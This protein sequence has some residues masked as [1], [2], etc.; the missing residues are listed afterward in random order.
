MDDLLDF[1]GVHDD[2]RWTKNRVEKTKATSTGESNAQA[3]KEVEIKRLSCPV[4]ESAMVSEQTNIGEG[5]APYRKRRNMGASTMWELH[6]SMSRESQ[7]ANEPS[8]SSCVHETA[9]NTCNLT[10]VS[11]AYGDLAWPA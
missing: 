2:C 3:G 8:A 7:C 10:P 11:T 5:V 9:A 1:I 6:V 4:F